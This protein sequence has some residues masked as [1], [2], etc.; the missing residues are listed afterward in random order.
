M[1]HLTLALLL[2]ALAALPRPATAQTAHSDETLGVTFALPQSDWLEL[3]TTA[4]IRFAIGNLTTPEASEGA[5]W[6]ACFLQ[7]GPYPETMTPPQS[8]GDL[9]SDMT[10]KGAEIFA[11]SRG[12]GLARQGYTLDSA[13]A[14]PRQDGYPSWDYHATGEIQSVPVTL[15]ARTLF[16][17]TTVATL[18][19]ELYPGNA[20]QGTDLDATRAE[21]T[22]ILASL[23]PLPAAALP[24]GTASKRAD[25]T[26]SLLA[27]IGRGIGIVI[28]ALFAI[29]LT[30]R[31]TRRKRR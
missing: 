15:T 24:E 18:S 7:G 25:R 21:I 2:G 14:T 23:A 1:R 20:P 16:L 29:L 4:P 12:D 13:E 31:L 6:R 5:L 9:L 3:E 22:Q 19:C 28:L 10:D 30:R 8:T 17:K 11:R 26:D 27:T